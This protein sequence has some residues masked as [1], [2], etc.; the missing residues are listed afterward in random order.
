M[1]SKPRVLL[2]LDDVITDFADELVSR[3]NRKYGTNFTKE[4]C[5]R[6]ELNEIF[7]H[8][9]LELIDEEDFFESVK[10]KDGAVEYIKKWI[11]EDG[12]DVFVVTSCLKPENY[13]KKIKWFNNH[14]PFFPTGRVIPL[15]EKSAVWGDVLVDDRPKNLN[16][17]MDESRG[18][19]KMGLLFDAPHNKV[20]DDYIR[21]NNFK[22]LDDIFQVFF[23]GC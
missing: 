4:H 3:Y 8:N 20:C 14:M 6:W 9:I 15:T 13:I 18:F 5:T 23:K 12:F 21:V 19:P 22:K 16:D 2:D 7:E 17:W 1:I 11:E 10:P